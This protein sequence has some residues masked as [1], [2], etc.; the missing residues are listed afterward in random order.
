MHVKNSASSEFALYLS[1][2]LVIVVVSALLTF[3]AYD[4][5]TLPVLVAI[6]SVVNLS[7]FLVFISQWS[8][9]KRSRRQ[10]LLWMQAATI[11]TL[12]L[13]LD[14]SGVAILSIVW[15]VQATE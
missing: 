1:G 15:I 8:D 4:Q 7:S 10:V 9:P 3:I 2:I 13:L 14:N 12:Y 6:L 5:D 11:V